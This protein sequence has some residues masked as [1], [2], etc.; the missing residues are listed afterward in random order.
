MLY[1]VTES[2]L[3]SSLPLSISLSFFSATPYLPRFLWIALC[4]PG[5]SPKVWTKREFQ[6]WEGGTS[7]YTNWKK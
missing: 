1:T 3:I 4:L 7:S 5:S 6:A 2:S